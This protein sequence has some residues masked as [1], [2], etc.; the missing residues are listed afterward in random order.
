[1]EGMTLFP[2]ENMPSDT[3]QIPFCDFNVKLEM[4]P[5]SEKFGRGCIIQ[6]PAAMIPPPA[7]F[8]IVA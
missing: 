8:L 7:L 3:P 6:L 4:D 5:D 1:V 2:H